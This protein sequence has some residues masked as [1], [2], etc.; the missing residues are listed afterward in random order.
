MVENL[1]SDFGTVA[2]GRRLINGERIKSFIKHQRSVENPEQ[3]DKS[4]SEEKSIPMQHFEDD[5]QLKLKLKHIMDIASL[6]ARVADDSLEL[7]LVQKREEEVDF[8]N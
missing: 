6:E 2:A 8:V 5:E 7:E 1:H 3:I 4:V